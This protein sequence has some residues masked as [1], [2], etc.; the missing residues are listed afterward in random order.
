[1]HKTK[2]LSKKM[3]I[4]IKFHFCKN[5]KQKGPLIHIEEKIEEEEGTNTHLQVQKKKNK[6]P[7]SS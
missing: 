2:G 7:R 4:S 5:N 3:M 1:M 6:Y